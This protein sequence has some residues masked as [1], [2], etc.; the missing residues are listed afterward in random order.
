MSSSLAQ[1]TVVLEPAAQGFADAT[2]T[3]PFLFELGPAKGRETLD[4]VQA[5]PV[6]QP[7]VEITEVIVPTGRGGT[8]SR[9]GNDS[10]R[11]LRPCAATGRVPAIVYTDPALAA[12]MTIKAAHIRDLRAGVK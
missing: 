12:G 3:P 1:P 6:D 8:F 5:G 9:S 2:A 10:V 11:I 7:A 4:Q